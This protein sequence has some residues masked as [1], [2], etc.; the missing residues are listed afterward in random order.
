[1]R[2][3]MHA[4]GQKKNLVK[5]HL[6]SPIII[7]SLSITMFLLTFH[8]FPSSF[9]LSHHIHF[10]LIFLF[11]S[12]APHSAKTFSLSLKLSINFFR[13][14]FPLWCVYLQFEHNSIGSEVSF[15]CKWMRDD[16]AISD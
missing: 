8:H 14:Y 1:M 9:L 10:S 7:E 11:F 16:G 13:K 5:N 4:R 12:L 3:F 15:P 2:I 6:H